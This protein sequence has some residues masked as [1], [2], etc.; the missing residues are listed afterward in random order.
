MLIEQVKMKT[1]RKKLAL[2]DLRQKVR[3]LKIEVH[4]KRRTGRLALDFSMERL[5]ESMTEQNE[6]GDLSMRPCSSFT[7]S[8][9]DLY[10]VI[11]QVWTLWDESRHQ[12]PRVG[13]ILISIRDS[14]KVRKA[15]I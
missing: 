14:P 3:K 4:Y 7:A 2:A 10:G 13:V 12:G 6:E 9:N 1:S 15:V 11:R 8:K 5:F